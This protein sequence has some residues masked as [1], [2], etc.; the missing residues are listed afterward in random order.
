[1]IATASKADCVPTSLRRSGRLDLEIELTVPSADARQEILNIYLKDA[2]HC[3]TEEE[4]QFIARVRTNHKDEGENNFHMNF[5][6]MPKI[7]SPSPSWGEKWLGTAPT[8]RGARMIKGV[9]STRFE[10]NRRGRLGA[11][12]Q[13]LSR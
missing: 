12:T 11:V 3:L 6:V 13:K 2:H 9:V 10:F 8:S 1:M 4:I 5:S 7:S